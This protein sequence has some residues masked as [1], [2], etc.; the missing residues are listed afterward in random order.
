MPTVHHY[1]DYAI[2]DMVEGAERNVCTS[3]DKGKSC[4]ENEEDVKK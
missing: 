4:D 3:N 1:T 2:I